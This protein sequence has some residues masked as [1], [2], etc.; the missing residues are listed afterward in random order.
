MSWGRHQEKEKERTPKGNEATWDWS[1][2][3]DR[4]NLSHPPSHDD[5]VEELPTEQR[6]GGYR[7]PSL[8]P[9]LI[10][11]TTNHPLNSGGKDEFSTGGR[12]EK[13]LPTSPSTRANKNDTGSISKSLLGSRKSISPRTTGLNETG[14]QENGS[15]GLGIGSVKEE[16]EWG[17]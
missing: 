10:G 17:W 12:R 8:T 15:N 13:A 2:F 16:D 4:P 5:T 11:T 1:S 14:G 6:L 9:A 3:L 7:R